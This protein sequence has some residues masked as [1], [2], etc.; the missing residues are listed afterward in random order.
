MR[1]YIACSS[2]IGTAQADSVLVG[3]Q[4]TSRR[5]SLRRAL[6]DTNASPSENGGAFRYSEAE[7]SFVDRL[8][9]KFPILS[10][11]G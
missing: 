6:P 11:P 2:S 8:S 7:S 1:I 3:I 9:M 10:C 4:S 5:A